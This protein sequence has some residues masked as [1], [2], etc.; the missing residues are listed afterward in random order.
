[1]VIKRKLREEY[2]I[3]KEMNSKG[4]WTQEVNIIPD[5]LREIE[6]EKEENF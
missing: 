5:V 2:K 4:E 3:I 1:M 6:G